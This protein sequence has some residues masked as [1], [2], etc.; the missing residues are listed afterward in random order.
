VV[1]YIIVARLATEFVWMLSKPE[2]WLQNLQN[3]YRVVPIELWPVRLIVFLPLQIGLKF[4]QIGLKFHS[5]I[6]GPILFVLALLFVLSMAL[7]EKNY[8]LFWWGLVTVVIVFGAPLVVRSPDENVGYL[9]LLVAIVWSI[10]SL[11]LGW[12]VPYLRRPSEYPKIWAL[13]AWLAAASLILVILFIQANWWTLLLTPL[14]FAT[15]LFFWRRV[16]IE[17][18]WPLIA[19]SIAILVLGATQLAQEARFVN[20]QGLS[21]ALVSEPLAKVSP[22]QEKRTPDYLITLPK[23]PFAGLPSW[24]FKGYQGSPYPA[25]T[26]FV[27]E[28]TFYDWLD[29]I[30]R[31]EDTVRR[32]AHSQPTVA[33]LRKQAADEE[34]RGETLASLTR[35]DVPQT[36]VAQSN[37]ENLLVGA[38]ARIESISS[39]VAQLNL[40]K[41]GHWR[42]YSRC[43]LSRYLRKNVPAT[44]SWMR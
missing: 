8:W 20:I 25:P 43:L 24:F 18:Y 29:A 26:P 31:Q 7:S 15:G 27:R 33:E 4:L 34:Q 13:V 3:L 32:L 1:A 16:P 22:P 41:Q 23:L 19:L 17:D 2:D 14:L 40:M 42:K 21:G 9:L 6:W 11:L 44:I 12:A 10:P 37:A 28:L 5:G 39:K 36:T 38:R 35:K 30:S